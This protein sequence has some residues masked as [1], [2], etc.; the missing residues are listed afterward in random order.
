MKK[1]KLTIFIV[2]ERVGYT[3]LMVSVYIC[4]DIKM[5]YFPVKVR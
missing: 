2:F 4:N 5:F 3:E 1:L